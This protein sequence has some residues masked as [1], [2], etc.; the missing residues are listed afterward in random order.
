MPA[1]NIVALY[2]YPQILTQ[3][4]SGAFDQ[5]HDPGGA[6]PYPGI[7]RCDGCGR[8]IAIARDNT[9]PP[10]DHHQHSLQQGSIRWRLV[11]SHS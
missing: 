9:L 11:V 5:I 2:K 4:Q 3:S 6:A 1:E 8:E 7:Y 10:Q